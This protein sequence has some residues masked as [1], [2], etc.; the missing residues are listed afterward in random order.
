MVRMEIEKPTRAQWAVR[1]GRTALAFIAKY[2]FMILCT[3]LIV[4]LTP[5]FVQS[6]TETKELVESGVVPEPLFNFVI[7]SVGFCVVL[8][9]MHV[10]MK[11]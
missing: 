10:K 11:R 5:A 1:I 8:F 7:C 6:L 9:A 2:G 4:A 3:L